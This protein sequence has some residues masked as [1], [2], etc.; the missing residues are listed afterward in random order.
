MSC[1]WSAGPRPRPFR[2]RAVRRILRDSA[3]IVAISRWTAG[4][5]ADLARQL[6][7]VWPTERVRVVSPGVDSAR[8]RPGLGTDLVRARFGLTARRWLLTVARLMPHKGID[9]GLE[10]LADLRHD[11]LDVGYI[12]A[13]DGPA[14]ADLIRQAERLGVTE[15]VR[16][17]GFVAEED[18][19]ALY[20]LADVYLGLSREDGAEVEGFGLALLEAQASGL[21]V[22]A[23]ASGGTVDALV[24]GI[25]GVLVPP[26]SRREIHQALTA[27]LQ[28]PARARTM[29]AAGRARA[30]R[31]GSWARVAADLEAAAEAFRTAAPWGSPAGR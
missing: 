14:R 24:P 18:L 3:G 19:P 28:D 17:C 1:C 26:S 2:T 25:S 7:L 12:V 9:R 10:A 15:F 29:G 20:G 13:G 11:G 16:W 4:R 27:L 22:V 23:G 5:I 8:F 31:E 30:E 21:P 6:H